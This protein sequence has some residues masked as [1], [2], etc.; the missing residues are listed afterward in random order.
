MPPLKL[1]LTQTA[2]RLGLSKGAVKKLEAQGH[3][4]NLRIPRNENASKRFRLFDSVEVRAVAAKLKSG[5]LTVGRTAAAS[6]RV[7]RSA[8]IEMSAPDLLAG[9][10]VGAGF[11]SR[12]A[13]IEQKLDYLIRLLS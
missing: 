11:G 8:P 12:L 4:H 1:D 6:R 7:T 10:S 5:E 3:L 13:N 2:E 9:T